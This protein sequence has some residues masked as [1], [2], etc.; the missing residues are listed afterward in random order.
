MVRTVI[1]IELKTTIEGF[2]HEQFQEVINSIK[3]G[4]MKREFEDNNKFKLK[5]SCTYWTDYK[6]VKSKSN[7]KK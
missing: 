5:A 1:T 2:E 7:G 6:Q 4:E 3:S